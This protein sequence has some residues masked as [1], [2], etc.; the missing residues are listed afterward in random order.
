[1][2]PGDVVG[3]RIP[4]LLPPGTHHRRR[5][6]QRA[7]TAVPQPAGR[8][9]RPPGNRVVTPAELLRGDLLHGTA[10]PQPQRRYLTQAEQIAPE[11]AG[12][13][14]AQAA[15]WLAAFGAAWPMPGRDGLLQRLA[16]TASCRSQLVPHDQG[17]ASLD[18]QAPG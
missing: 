12:I 14:D 9:R 5:P 17:P 2:A 6:R 13:I 11:V 3:R 7:G 15:K 10:G 1:M 4:H 16:R 8:A 18:C